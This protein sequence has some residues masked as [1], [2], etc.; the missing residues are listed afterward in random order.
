MSKIFQPFPRFVILKHKHPTYRHDIAS[1]EIN[2]GCSWK[3][4]EITRGATIAY[5]VIRMQINKCVT[6]QMVGHKQLILLLDHC[7]RSKGI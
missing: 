6:A 5:D 2:A 1:Q 4:I 3:V 7:Y